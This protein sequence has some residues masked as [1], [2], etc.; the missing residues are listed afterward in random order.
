MNDRFSFV[1]LFLCFLC[2]AIF[3][4]VNAQQVV[5]TEKVR[6]ERL[7]QHDRVIGSIKA[8]SDANLAVRESGYIAKIFVNEGSRV[9]AGDLLLKL[10]DQRLKA[11]LAQ[12]QAEVNRVKAQLKQR[13]IE[14]TNAQADVKAYTYTAKKHAISK[15]QLRLAKTERNVMQAAIKEAKALI[16]AKQA[17]AQLLQVRLKDLSLT[18]PFAGIVTERFAE[19]G[20]WFNQGETAISL[21]KDAQ[22]EAW[23]EVP[24]RFANTLAFNRTKKISLEVNGKAVEA[25]RQAIIRKVD[26]RARTFILIARFNNSQR[27][28]MTGM[29]VL[30]WLPIDRKQKVLTVNKNALVQRNHHYNVFKISSTK[31]GY[32]A[33]SIPV[34]ILFYY[35]KRVAISS[36]KLV[37]GNQVVIEGN[38]R[39]MDGPVVPVNQ[40]AIK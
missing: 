6:S 39:L 27:R 8:S 36:P 15:R 23:L 28:W 7:Q 9:R 30:A 11:E 33:T 18:A 16:V 10:D 21:V 5:K 20:E 31:E 13:Q 12:A 4:P 29:S 1:S 40:K 24:E 22:L 2:L 3:L 19:P 38:E 25:K 37:A 32:M 34:N 17:Q 26:N 35:G 14:L